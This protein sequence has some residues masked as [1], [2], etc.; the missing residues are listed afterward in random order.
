L[1]TSSIPS[2][3]VGFLWSPAPLVN[4]PNITNPV[5]IPLTDTTLFSVNAWDSISGCAAV[6][7]FTINVIGASLQIDSV[8][9]AYDSVCRGD[10]NTLTAYVFG[11]SGGYSYQWSANALQQ[12]GMSTQI[13]ASLLPG[14][15]PY[16]L[17]V[18]DTITLEQVSL[19]GTFQKYP[20]PLVQFGQGNVCEGDTVEFQVVHTAFSPGP[21]QYA[22]TGPGGF[23]GS[24]NPLQ[25]PNATIWMAGTYTVL[26]TDANGCRDD[27]F[28][29]LLVR[30]TPTVS[31]SGDTLVCPNQ[32][33]NLL[34]T[35]GNQYLWSTG[36][37]G[38]LVTVNP[39]DT[40]QY[41]VTVTALNGCTS[42][43]SIYVYTLPGIV[44]Y[45]DTSF[46]E[47]DSVLIH[48]T[49]YSQSGSYLDSSVTAAGCDSIISV[50]LT[51][52]PLPL[53]LGLP[54][55]VNLSLPPWVCATDTAIIALIKSQPGVAYYLVDTLTMNVIAGPQVGSGADLYYSIPPAQLDG[56]FQ[57]LAVDTSTGCERVLDSILILN[58]I[59]PDVSI[60]PGDTS[61]CLGE[62]IQLTAG[63]AQSYVW[64]TTPSSTVNPLQINVLG[65]QSYSV[66]GTLF[67]CVDSARISITALYPDSVIIRDTICQG[68]NLF[69]GGQNLGLSGTY[70]DYL[71]NAQGCDSIVQLDLHV[72]PLPWGLGLLSLSHPDTLCE[73][74]DAQVLLGNTQVDKNYTLFDAISGTTYSSPQPGT[75]GILTFTIPQGSTGSLYGI[76]AI[77]TLSGCMQPLDTLISFTVISLPVISI[78]PSD[79]SICE[80]DSIV[81]Q[82]SG[83]QQYA[84]NTNPPQYLPLTTVVAQGIQTYT[85]TV[86]RF[87]CSDSASVT[88]SSLPVYRDTLNDTICEGEV[89]SFG[90]SFLTQGGIYS[91][92]LTSVFGCDSTTTLILIVDPLPYGLAGPT[93][94]SANCPLFMSDPRDAKVYPLV[95]IG[96]QCW[97]VTGLKYGQQRTPAQGQQNNG[98]AEMYCYDNIVANCN[99]YG[100]LYTWDEA[101]AYAPGVPQ[102]ICPPGWHIPTDEEWKV[103]EGSADALYPVGSPVWNNTNFRGSDAGRNMKTST[104]WS[105]GGLGTNQS[106]FTSYASGQFFG[107]SYIEQGTNA[108]YWSSTQGSGSGV[109]T[110]WVRNLRNTEDR[111]NRTTSAKTRGHTVR[112]LRDL[113]LIPPMALKLD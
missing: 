111:V 15:V 39:T 105:S 107:S 9:V 66:T 85:V 91:D 97:M 47:G 6:D 64:N 50:S 31:L 40:T 42:A 18:T 45:V 52:H 77:D 106:G 98:I 84:W 110:A 60:T 28:N 89:V 48:G 49:W 63:G 32:A 104:G 2:A 29:T 71:L 70:Y 35:G 46:C 5:T 83:G 75:G 72:E 112:C 79:T 88:I 109:G 96:S 26:M 54:S 59:Q 27:F 87:G 12:G 76:E 17:T 1:F 38:S 92:T 7:T 90:G 69:F 56:H 95:Q 34:A 25:I 11:G 30:D 93:G 23:S 53:G 36:Q 13:P 14:P 10:T 43:G 67:G 58:V 19:S 3:N 16:S 82:A 80:G 103:L 81:L 74:E 21:Y 37:T 78:I 86:T 20:Q 61:V 51:M 68:D 8:V 101:M 108:W 99:F 57:F 100:G 24:G 94:P 4:N 44:S 33:A 62:I 22:W 55:Y 73:N 113:S 41:E 102:G 65:D